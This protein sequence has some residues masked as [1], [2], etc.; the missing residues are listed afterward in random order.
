M[1][2]K[3]KLLRDFKDSM[4]VWRSQST[5]YR[6]PRLISYFIDYIGVKS[7][8][9]RSDAM[10]FLNHIINSGMSKN[11]A[12]WAS[13]ILKQFYESLGIKYPL[14][15]GD[16][17]RLEPGD[18]NAPVFSPN[19]IND[20]IGAVKSKG[21]PM[22]K[23][24]LALSTTYGFRRQ[25]LANISDND[26]CNGT[27]RV[28]TVKGKVVREHIV[29]DEIVP[30]LTGYKLKTVHPQTMINLFLRIQSLAKFKHGDREGF[31][32]IRRSLVTELL[33][34]GVPIHVAY[35]YIGWKLSPRLG[36]IGV[37]AKPSSQEV[38]EIVMEKHPFIPMWKE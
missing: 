28:S 4:P 37:Y 33:N 20:L 7:T 6:Y 31:H 2:T 17:P 24:Y 9:T 23:A 5:L 13:Y 25:E 35:L 8:Y 27:I 3:E 14:R 18:V 34:A 11:Y 30:Y 22:M 38:D 36:I 26:I 12:I 10:R 15:A 16:L 29:P 19:Y 21:T 1:L 32:S